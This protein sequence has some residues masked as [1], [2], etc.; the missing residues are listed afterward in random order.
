MFKG[1]SEKWDTTHEIHY[2]AT[3][4]QLVLTL[5]FQGEIYC[6]KMLAKSLVLENS[7]FLHLGGTLVGRKIKNKIGICTDKASTKSNTGIEDGFHCDLTRRSRSSF[8]CEWNILSDSGLFFSKNIAFLTLSPISILSCQEMMYKDCWARKTIS[9][10]Y[11]AYIDSEWMLGY[12]S[13]KFQ[14]E[15]WSFSW[16]TFFWGEAGI[17][18]GVRSLRVSNSNYGPREKNKRSI[19]VLVLDLIPGR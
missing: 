4:L 17:I 3:L 10:I 8:L 15:M 7:I 16:F 19:I 5:N 1:N 13:F 18:L 11:T 12:L 6:L 2:L 14:A 9:T